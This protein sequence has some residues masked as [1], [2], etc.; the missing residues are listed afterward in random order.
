MATSQKLGPACLDCEWLRE[1][2][3]IAPTPPGML[4]LRLVS[5]TPMKFAWKRREGA[6]GGPFV[7]QPLLALMGWGPWRTAPCSIPQPGRRG[8]LGLWRPF[9]ALPFR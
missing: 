1:A 3:S 4:A 2:Q 6:G 7:E 8:E 5:E 9:G